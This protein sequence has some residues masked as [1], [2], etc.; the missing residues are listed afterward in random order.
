MTKRRKLR[1]AANDAENLPLRVARDAGRVDLLAAGVPLLLTLA[2]YL[3]SLHNGFVYDD[4]Y[5]V[6]GNPFI[7]E[8]SF[9]WKSFTHD[10]WW[11]ADPSRLPQSFYYR[12]FEDVWLA[13]NY[14]LFG[15]NPPGWHATMIVVQLVGVYLV[16]RLAQEL[17]RE[18]IA[19]AIAATL[20]GLIPI[21]AGAIA[22]GR[23]I[24]LPM[25]TEFQVAAML[26]FVRRAAAPRRNLALALALYAA[27]LLSH[28]SPAVF[29]GI[30]AA[31][32]F[33]LE[34]PRE[35]AAAATRGAL[36]A[37]LR[38]CAVAAAPFAGVLA[39]YAVLRLVVLGLVSLVGD[40]NILTTAERLLSVPGLLAQYMLL[41]LTP[42]RAGPAHG[43]TTA[44][45][46]LTPAFYQP[47][48]GLLAGAAVCVLIFHRHKHRRL[49]LFCGVWV[50]VTIAPFLNLR[51]LG[52]ESLI[53][54]R[55]LFMPSVAWT[56]FLGDFAAGFIATRDRRAYLAAA[57]TAALALVYGVSLWRVEPFWHDETTFYTKCIEMDPDS[58]LCHSNLGVQFENKND[59]GAAEREHEIAMRLRPNDGGELYNLAGVHILMGKIDLAEQELK[60]ALPLIKRPIAARYIELAQVADAVGDEQTSEQALARAAEMPEGPVPVAIGRARIRMSHND[61]AGAEAIL[62]ALPSEDRDQLDVWDLLATAAIGGGD[63]AEALNDYEAALKLAPDSANLHV[64]RA[65]MLYRLGRH[66][67]AVEECR[68]ALQLDPGNQRAHQ[69]MA[70]LSP[71]ASQSP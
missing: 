13:L 39:A 11:F 43:V 27:A 55:Y 26:C 53:Q 22:W 42:W 18:R 7:G 33:L 9:I 21:H 50:F 58:W 8:W 12:P 5:M 1:V 16:Y 56:I 29:P 38:T 37:R 40:R 10:L 3:P 60:R 17:T 4:R 19:A 24:P 64:L 68:R 15:L 59:L 67:E 51:A 31:Y 61:Y 20:F 25:S 23:S 30:I 35:D 65:L 34:H 49:Y 62:K 2:A 28:E 47:V 46:I 14:H 63:F 45:A 48:L 44:K 71:A 70:R 57:A 36:A 32:V 41:M 52:V 66:D 54:D 6:A 69:L